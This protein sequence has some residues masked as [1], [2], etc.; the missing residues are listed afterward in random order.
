MFFLGIPPGD[1]SCSTDMEQERKSMS[2]NFNNER[3]EGEKV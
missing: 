3:R 2:K 1:A